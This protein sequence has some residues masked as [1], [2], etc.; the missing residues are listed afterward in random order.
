MVLAPEEYPFSSYRYYAFGAADALITPNLAY[1]GLSASEES[2]RKQ[3][4]A[5]VVDSGIINSRILQ[6]RLFI[7]SDSFVRKLEE[8]CK[9]RNTSLD[10]GRPKKGGK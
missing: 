10:R 3:Y 9:I 6:A 8:D 5:F 7:G 1:L 4:I 2:R